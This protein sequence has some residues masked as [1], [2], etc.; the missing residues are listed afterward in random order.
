MVIFMK[1]DNY[2][3]LGKKITSLLSNKQEGVK[4]WSKWKRNIEKKNLII[5]LFQIN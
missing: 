4:S 2:N 1:K 3:I 5:L